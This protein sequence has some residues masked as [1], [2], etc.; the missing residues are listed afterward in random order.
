M[1][2]NGPPN[3]ILIITAPILRPRSPYS[4][5]HCTEP[6][7]PIS[8]NLSKSYPSFTRP[9]VSPATRKLR[10]RVSTAFQRP[11]KKIIGPSSST[12]LCFPGKIQTA[13]M[14]QVT[15]AKITLPATAFATTTFRTNSKLPQR[16]GSS[17]QGPLNLRKPPMAFPFHTKPWPSA[18]GWTCKMV[19]GASHCA[20]FT[21]IMGSRVFQLGFLWRH[22]F[23]S[24]MP[25]VGL[26][27]ERTT[28]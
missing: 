6:A 5:G 27:H 22:G 24:G 25:V 9:Q 20:P 2:Y 8:R 11:L 10:L 28:P 7:Q 18:S 26:V 13:E 4:L 19:L 21:G 14:L 12:S 1:W 17:F 3:P 23:Q 15:A 16:V